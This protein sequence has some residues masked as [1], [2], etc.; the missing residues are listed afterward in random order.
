MSVRRKECSRDNRVANALD[1]QPFR[2]EV[3]WIRGERDRFGGLRVSR[4]A[5]LTGRA[6]A[7][8]ASNAHAR[9]QI[10]MIGAGR[11]DSRAAEGQGFE[12]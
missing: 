1:P 9:H 12:P 7:G 10:V 3:A 5:E 2:G 11:L 6:R 4:T 8:A